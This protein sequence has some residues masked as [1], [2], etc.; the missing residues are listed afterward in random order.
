MRTN[1]FLPFWAFLLFLLDAAIKC[2]AGVKADDLVGGF[3]ISESTAEGVLLCIEELLIKC[4]LGSINQ[5]FRM[6]E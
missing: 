6:M 3:E 2:R 1:P 4:H 5:I